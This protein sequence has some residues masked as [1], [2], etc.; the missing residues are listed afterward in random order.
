MKVEYKDVKPQ[1][2]E[3]AIVSACIKWLWHN[4]CFVWRNNTGAANHQYTR[5][6][7]SRGESY[8]RYGLPGSADIIG[9]N[10]W[11]RFIAIECK[12]PGKDLEPHQAKF[13][14]QIHEKNGVYVLARSVD[15]LE[16]NRVLL[17]NS[18][19]AKYADGS[20][21]PKRIL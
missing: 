1:I 20:L 2:R 21:T 9:T 12:V 13:R 19:P 4:G 16:A 18:Y 6:D 5:K 10:R 14:D 17:L 15:D 7:G 8:I 3:S 11:G